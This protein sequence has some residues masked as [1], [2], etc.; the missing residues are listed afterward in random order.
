MTSPRWENT[1]RI[2]LIA[3]TALT[4]L[5]ATLC[6]LPF[7]YKN[8]IENKIYPFWV[9]WFLAAHP[10]LLAAIL[11]G[12]GSFLHRRR[13]WAVG[14]TAFV[15]YFFF[16][17]LAS[18]IPGSESTWI[19]I[20]GVVPLLIWETLLAIPRARSLCWNASV[21]NEG[22]CARLLSA[23][24]AGALCAWASLI[25]LRN[26]L[27]VSALQWALISTA[28]A[29]QHALFFCF[30]AALLEA[31]RRAARMFRRP[32][33]A[34]AV[35]EALLVLLALRAAV[36]GLLMGPLD[37]RGAV[38]QASAWAWS[39]AALSAWLGAGLAMRIGKPEST[40]ELLFSVLGARST[41]KKRAA[42]L[43]AAASAP[44]WLSLALARND[45]NGTILM[46]GVSA[47]WAA[48]FAVLRPAEGSGK[49]KSAIAFAAALIATG[50]LSAAAA[51]AA[52]P[53]LRLR[54]ISPAELMNRAVS[55][56]PSL[57]VVRRATQWGVRTSFFESLRQNTSISRSEPIEPRR[58]DLVEGDWKP[59]AER[60]PIFIIVMDSLRQDY[61][62]AYNP[63]ARFTP[64]IDAF[65]RESLLWQKSFTAYGATGLSEPSIWAGSLLLHKLYIT[66]FEPMNSL[67][68]LLDRLGYR[69]FLTPD[70]IVSAL[71]TKGPELKDLEKQESAEWVLCA[72]L[73]RIDEELDN[74]PSG[75]PLFFYTQP[76]DIHV[77]IIERLKRSNVTGKVYK[78]FDAAYASRLERNDACFGRFIS[79]LKKRGLYDKSI[80]VLTS[81]HGDSLGEEGR[82]G[83]AYTIYPEIL[84]IP[85]IM[86]IPKALAGKARIDREGPA[87]LIDIAPTLYQ[88]LGRGAPRLD[89]LLGRPLIALDGSDPVAWRKP[90][91][92][93]VSSYGPVYGILRGTDRLFIGDGVN[94]RY[95]QFDLDAPPGDRGTAPAPKAIAEGEAKV[96]AWLD[97]LNKFWGRSP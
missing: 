90:E 60:P 85:I 84:R 2:I 63:A 52:D 5:F 82:W 19:M 62:G 20:M 73:A 46:I 29:L 11:A 37:M 67:E 64:A 36:S 7:V 87:F 14:S 92:M 16:S 75:K 9:A 53:L 76:Q 15:L 10:Y 4:C 34:Y 12:A 58:I 13:G 79:S 3:W 80:I 33:A 94:F 23:A 24:A 77:S 28:S 78:G 31:A 27:E 42:M 95:H 43:M 89:P 86:H 88:L 50:W 55:I 25:S 48:V 69:K 26:T 68:R 21:E 54:G 18:L 96:Q 49:D 6:S 57:R 17:P 91:Q 39:A 30:A 1:L 81:D 65:A 47:S 70:A 83:H 93:V 32:Q 74:A 22:A 56:D 97:R 35:A 59:T 44:I 51:W 41:R 38:A 40:G 61:I 71:W 72:T 66:P 45:W 8:F